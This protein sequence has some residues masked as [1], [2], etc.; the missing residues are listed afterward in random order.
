MNGYMMNMKQ[1]LARYVEVL[2]DREK[3]KV[4]IPGKLSYTTQEFQLTARHRPIFLTV[5]SSDEVEFISAH[6][7]F[8][9]RHRNISLC[10]H[11]L[12]APSLLKP[13]LCCPESQRSTDLI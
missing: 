13:Y 9:C 3:K 8:I 5:P 6:L 11:H 1:I 2:G 4:I 10:I 7:Y 12:S